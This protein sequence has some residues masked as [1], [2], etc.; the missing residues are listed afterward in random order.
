MCVSYDFNC[1]QWQLNNSTNPVLFLSNKNEMARRKKRGRSEERAAESGG[2]NKVAPQKQM[3]N[4]TNSSTSFPT[5][6]LSVCVE[7]LCGLRV[8]VC[9][10]WLGYLKLPLNLPSSQAIHSLR[11]LFLATDTHTLC[12]SHTDTH[13]HTHA[14]GVC[15]A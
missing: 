10:C 9:V 15:G 11:T 8:S 3:Q 2:K 13:T 14:R 12:M 1:L 6:L 5:G 7:Y 4:N